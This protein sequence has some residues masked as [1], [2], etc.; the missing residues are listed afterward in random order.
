MRIDAHHHLWTYDADRYPWIGDGMGVLQRDFTTE[1]LADSMDAVGLDA[2]VT[3]QARHDVDETI[4][5]L[6]VARDNPEILGVV[7]WVDLT[8]EGVDRQL[9]ELSENPM[10]VGIRHALQDE[11]DDAFMLRDDF[12]RGVARLHGYGL[13]YDILIYPRHLENTLSFV[14]RHPDQVFILDHVAKPSI[15][16]GEI[17]SWREGLTALADRSNCY[18]KLSGLVTE[19]DWSERTPVEIRPYLDAALEAFGPN[20]LMFGSDWP[21]CTLACDYATWYHLVDEYTSSLSR[22]EQSRIWG[23]TAA[24][25]YRLSG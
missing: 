19:A 16:T 7:G 24:E 3:V 20:R 1:E 25:A 4:W 2:A 8:D 18:C 10:L 22:D 12:N 11:S 17:T 9:L 5:L 14:D 6:N 15:R 21:V 23:L 13:T